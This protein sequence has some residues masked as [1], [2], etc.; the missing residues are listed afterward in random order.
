MCGIYD[1]PSVLSLCLYMTHILLRNIET[2]EENFNAIVE[3][4]TTSSAKSI[5]KSCRYRL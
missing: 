2:S 4:F 3:N 1:T 5:D